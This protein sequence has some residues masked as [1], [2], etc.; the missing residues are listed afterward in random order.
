METIEVPIT[1]RQ[2]SRGLGIPSQQVQAVVNLLD[3]GNTVPFITRYRKDQTGGLDEDQIRRIQ[4]RLTKLRQL[5]ERKKTILRSIESQGK[6]T[7][8]LA[9]R[10]RSAGSAKRL[11]DLYLPY[12][13][14]KQTL[15]TIARQRGLDHFAREIL[16]AD[17]AAADLDSRAADYINPDKEI[18]TAADA[19]LGAGHI[20]AEQFSEKIELREKLREMLQRTGALRSVRV[21]PDPAR[22]SEGKSQPAQPQQDAASQTETVDP[23]PSNAQS[24]QAAAAPQQVHAEAM[25]AGPQ[26]GESVQAVTPVGDAEASQPP[27]TRAEADGQ[28]EGGT[29]GGQVAGTAQ[30]APNPPEA[31]ASEAIPADDHK[32]PAETAEPKKNQPKPSDS[33]KKA[34]LLKKQRKDERRV[35]AFSD[36]FDYQEEIRKI[37]PHRVLAINRG[38]RAKVLRVRIVCELEAMYQVVEQQCVPPEHPHA[39]FLRGCAR[40]ALVRLIQPSLERE[41]RRELTDRAEAH[42]VEVFAKNLRKLL[43]Q[44]PVRDRRVLAIDPGY[45]SGCKMAALDQFGNVL[46]H[47]VISLVGKPEKREAARQKVVALVDRFQISVLA[48]GN[49]TGC[50]ETELFVAELLENELGGRGVAYTIVNEAGASVYSTSPLGR[51]ELP[52]FDAAIR[53]AVSIGRRLLDPLSELVKI[54]PGSIGVGLYQ[55]DVKAKHLRDSLDAVVESCVNYVGVDVNTASPALLRYVSGLNQLTARRVYE[56]RRQ[57]GPF[58]NRGQLRDVPGVGETTFVQAAGFLKISGGDNPLDATWIHPESYDLARQVMER[59]GVTPQELAQKEK[60]NELAR[61]IEQLNSD[62][63]ATEL[64]AG[65]MTLQDILQQLSRPG[66]DPREDLPLPAFREGVLKLEDLNP[67]MELNGTV[68]NVVDFGA[69]VD[70]G[71]HDSGLVHVSQLADRFVRDPHEVVSVG[72]I[73]RVWVLSVDKERR[74]VSLTMIPPSTPPRDRKQGRGDA[75]EGEGKPPRRRGGDR[76][77][78]R[79]TRKEGEAGQHGKPQ[80]GQ[81]GRRER[82][83]SQSQSQRSDRPRPS[84]AKPAKPVEPISEEKIAGKEPLRSFS[85]LLQYCEAKGVVSTSSPAERAKKKAKQRKQSG[86][87]KKPQEGANKPQEGSP[88]GGD[89]PT[90]KGESGTAPPANTPGDKPAERPASEAEQR[91]TAKDDTGSQGRTETTSPGEAPTADHSKSPD[92][93]STDSTFSAQSS[94]APQ[95]GSQTSHTGGEGPPE[96]EANRPS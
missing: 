27:E 37:P 84:R 65:R 49:G 24:E 53:G 10:I 73:V 48:V 33:Q 68:L 64:A 30:S 51:E 38:E 36:Y 35:K 70:I 69:F 75:A 93:T 18:N 72:D 4:A 28:N 5:A 40:D 26:Q 62:A 79:D 45:R 90:I 88:A 7:E 31:S 76:R 95:E 13:P 3:E 58:R 87:G 89:S 83:R 12:K 44:P 43:L 57:H 20:L 82:S 61:Q 8:S 63:L 9:K 55:H 11:E 86:S 54:D 80:R 56:H 50:R 22:H 1:L 74:R 52:E 25:P 19:L 34:K 77:R 6:L 85:D 29:D 96:D 14:K 46:A 66:R 81:R 2:L 39:E 59:L 71:M 23:P 17:P 92:D 94:E 47:D 91:E 41:T 67:G 15:A 78:G 60:S 16:E 21:A 42:A 32:P